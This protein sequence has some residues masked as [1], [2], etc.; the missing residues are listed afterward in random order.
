VEKKFS[1]TLLLALLLTVFT[2][3]PALAISPHFVHTPEVTLNPD[4]TLTAKFKVGG[5]GDNATATFVLSAL[6]TVQYACI[7]GGGNHPQAANKETLSQNVSVPGT[8]TSDKNGNIN[9]VLTLAP[10]GPGSFTC[11]PGQQMVQ[12]YVNYSN[13]SITDPAAGITYTFPGTFSSGAL[14]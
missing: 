9:G 1:L 13:V 6:E 8:F 11:P 5:Y 12:T 2:A 7:N 4:R 14:L 10:I 3:L